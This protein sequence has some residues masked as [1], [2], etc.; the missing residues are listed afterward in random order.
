[1]ARQLGWIVDA[2]GAPAHPAVDQVVH[3]L[4]HRFNI[5]LTLKFNQNHNYRMNL[6][7]TREYTLL[8]TNVQRNGMPN[9]VQ[10]IGGNQ[11]ADQMIERL[12]TV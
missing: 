6:K 11:N 2:F 3:A 4:N 12:K 10:I 5:K 8:E 7:T 9:G 1:M